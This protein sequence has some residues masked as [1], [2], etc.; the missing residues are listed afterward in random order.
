[1]KI[2]PNC[3]K[4]NPEI[5]RDITWDF[6]IVYET[7]KEP[8]GVK[9]YLFGLITRLKYCNHIGYIFSPSLI[10]D[11]WKYGHMENNKVIYDKIN[12]TY[13]FLNK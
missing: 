6:D 1:M 12:P 2:C 3:G 11:N 10:I 8:I 5:K 4:H 7:C 9:F 13:K